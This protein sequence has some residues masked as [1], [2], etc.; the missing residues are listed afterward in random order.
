MKRRGWDN[1]RAEHIGL[2]VQRLNAIYECCFVVSAQHLYV[3]LLSLGR[4]SP[5]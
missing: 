3:P 2:A 1:T 5:P 4:D